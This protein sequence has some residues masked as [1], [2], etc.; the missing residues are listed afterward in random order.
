MFLF[1]VSFLRTVFFPFQ[2]NI[3]LTRT[4]FIKMGDFGVARSLDFTLALAQ[5]QIGNHSTSL[6]DR[7]ICDIY[8]LLPGTPYCV[9]PEIVGA[10]KYNAKVDIW[11]K[12]FYD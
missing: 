11:F 7:K 12:S 9:A 6:E 8:V 1:F 3:F 2:E 5:T 10:Q 4:G